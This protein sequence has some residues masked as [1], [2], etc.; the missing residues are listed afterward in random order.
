MDSANIAHI[1]VTSPDGPTLSV[2]D[3]ETAGFIGQYSWHTNGGGY[4]VRSVQ[5]DGKES[6]VFMHRILAMAPVGVE[7]DHINRD[8]LDNRL[9]NLRLASRSQNNANKSVKAHKKSSKYKG[10]YKNSNAT[11]YNVRLSVNGQKVYVGSYS[12]EIEAAKAYDQAALEHHG[13]FAALNFPDAA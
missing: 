2:V 5:V 9:E 7:V 1:E 3:A 4:A 11:T 10:V 6:L 13:E 8:R 12:D